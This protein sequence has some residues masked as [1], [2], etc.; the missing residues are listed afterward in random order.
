MPEKYKIQWPVYK[1]NLVIKVVLD[2]EVKQKCS[3]SAH[4]EDWGSKGG[5]KNNQVPLYC[6][7]SAACDEGGDTEPDEQL[8]QAETKTTNP[9][10]LLAEVTGVQHPHKNYG[11]QA[12]KHKEVSKASQ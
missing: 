1:T 11:L 3:S 12:I 2:C 8:L 4:C 9:R 10:N 6:A 5:K 7:T